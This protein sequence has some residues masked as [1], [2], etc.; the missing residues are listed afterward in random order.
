MTTNAYDQ[1]YRMKKVTAY[2]KRKWKNI[3]KTGKSAGSFDTTTSEMLKAQDEN[4]IILII[5]SIVQSN[6]HDWKYT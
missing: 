5:I 1:Y 6:L 4:G 2:W 3:Q